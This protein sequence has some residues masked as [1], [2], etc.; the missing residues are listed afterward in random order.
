[1]KKAKLVDVWRAVVVTALLGMAGHAARA[2]VPEAEWLQRRSAL[3]ATG[4]AVTHTGSTLVAVGESGKASVS[5]NGTTWRAVQTPVR[6]GLNAVAH[7]DG[8]LVAAADKGQLAISENEGRTWEKKQLEFAPNHIL[9]IDMETVHEAEGRWVVAGKSGVMLSSTDTENWNTVI[10]GTADNIKSL[11]HANGLW[12][13]AGDNNSFGYSWDGTNWTSGNMDLGGDHD[14]QSVTYSQGQFIAVASDGFVARSNTG[15]A[16]WQGEIVPGMAGAKAITAGMDRF[17][18]VTQ[19]GGVISSPDGRNWTVEDNTFGGNGI[20]FGGDSFVTVGPRGAFY[21]SPPL[22]GPRPG[23]SW[24]HPGALFDEGQPIAPLISL[25]RFSVNTASLDLVLEGVLFRMKTNGPTILGRLVFNRQPGDDEPGMFGV[26]WHFE[27]ESRIEVSGGAATV[28][29]GT[30]GKTVFRNPTDFVPSPSA[31]VVFTSPEGNFDTL[32]S[33]GTWWE[34]KEKD[35]KLVRRFDQADPDYPARLSK[36]TDRN[37]NVIVI[38]VNQMT[39]V[40]SQIR[41]GDGGSGFRTITFANAGGQW[42]IGL[43]DNRHVDLTVVSGN[44][45]DRLVAI[46]DMAGNRA[47]YSYNSEGYLTQ[48]TIL[49]LPNMIFR[50]QPR[51]GEAGQMLSEVNEGLRQTTYEFVKNSYGTVRRREPDGT[52]TTIES[53]DGR[54]TRVVDPAG[55]IRKIAYQNR[56]PVR[57]TEPSGATAEWEYDERGNPVKVTDALGR[58]TLYTY[59]WRDNLLTRKNALNWTT[60]YQYDT[61]SNLTRITT[62]MGFG[63]VLSYDTKGRLQSLRDARLNVTSFGYDGFGNLTSITNANTQTT[64]FHY[65]AS[66]MMFTGITDARGHRKDVQLDDNERIAR[67][68]YSSVTGTPEMNHA[69]DAFWQTSQTDELGHLTSVERNLHGFI[70]AVTTP[71]GHTRTTDYDADDHPVARTDAVGRTWKVAYDALGRPLV[72]ENPEGAR[73]SRRYD[74][75][76]RLA[77]ITDPAR[78]VT[79]FSYDAADQLKSVRHPDR[80]LILYDWDALGRISRITNTRNQE[81]FQQFDPDGRLI[82]IRHGTTTTAT[83]L[84]DAVGNLTRATDA[85]N[86]ATLYEYDN[87]NRLTRIT[88]TN[89]GKQVQIAYDATGNATQMTYPD[90]TVLTYTYDDYNRVPIP[91]SV[92]ADG[93]GTGREKANRVVGMAWS[94]GRTAAFQIDKAARLSRETHP[95]GWTSDY[96]FDADSR[97]MAL[98][99]NSPSDAVTTVQSGYDASGKVVFEEVD[100]PVAPPLPDTSTAS[101]DGANKL[102]RWNGRPVS[103][104]ADGNVTDSGDGRFTATYDAENRPVAMSINGQAITLTYNALG[105]RASKTMGG[106]TTRYCYDPSGRLLFEWDTA[107]IRNHLYR[108]ARLY[109]VG[110]LAN[111]YRYLHPD[112]NGNIVAISNDAGAVVETLAYGPHGLAATESETEPLG[113]AFVGAY[114]VGHDGGGIHHMGHRLYD[115]TTGRFLQRDPSGFQGGANLFLY[116]NGDPLNAIDPSGLW[117]LKRTAAG[118]LNVG[119]GAFKVAAGYAAYQTGVLSWWGAGSA[120]LGAKRIVDGGKL[121]YKGVTGADD[122]EQYGWKD[123]GKDVADPSG[124]IRNT[125]ESG[126]DY[127]QKKVND[128]LQEAS[129]PEEDSTDYVD[130]GDDGGLAFDEM[131]LE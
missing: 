99:H 103:H 77:A 88:E 43:P 91:S 118:L 32:T 100:H 117:S 102:K 97:L 95:N 24:D 49:G 37:G 119:Y 83:F 27:Y 5:E 20:A 60:T 47:A 15:E 55:A 30:G 36:I 94:G 106:V 42:Q 85:D 2:Q 107:G 127:L 51:S 131:L 7:G 72:S 4:N 129:T 69:F 52:V 45:Q 12:V 41:D 67:T 125:A 53:K 16:D 74:A 40:I 31:P 44:G 89:S 76:G 86:T 115:A 82:G 78:A 14:F 21:Q 108:G 58:V 50:Y 65:A 116:A 17:V 113:A 23:G 81:V 38:V 114:G 84:Y 128:A 22:F 48:L 110:S 6:T 46:R 1:M 3:T 10:S 122:D 63:T 96:V 101:F 80:S 19:N 75:D 66:G 25:P 56:L 62:P 105:L 18:V 79:T 34:L 111:G 29:S 126:S 98:W 28:V 71:L 121:A 35:T 61:A 104:D 33:F 64:Q 70:T 130:P 90:G 26:G 109:A 112:R 39:G 68:I 57:Y 13:S 59:D 8:T 92:A 9:T 87:V 93:A 73:I 124:G 120:A 123:M 54:M 11:T